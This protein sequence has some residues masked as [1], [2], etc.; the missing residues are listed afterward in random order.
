MLT[1]MFPHLAR[2]PVLLLTPRLIHTEPEWVAERTEDS[3]VLFVCLVIAPVIIKTNL[4]FNTGISLAR[5]PIFIACLFRV[6]VGRLTIFSP[7][8]Y[9]RDGE[10]DTWGGELMWGRR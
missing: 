5:R 1:D 10:K 8:Y 6:F 7:G 9:L 2:F 3:S 4:T